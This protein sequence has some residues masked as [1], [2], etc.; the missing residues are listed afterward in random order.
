M[1]RYFI[2]FYMFVFIL[3]TGCIGPVKDVS[4]H[5][6]SMMTIRDSLTTI[7][8]TLFPGDKP[9]KPKKGKH[10]YWYGTNQI[11]IT[12]GDYA[13]RPVDGIYTAF[14][15]S[16]GLV[17]KGNFDKGLKVGIWVRWDL[18]GN[19]IYCIKYRHGIAKDTIRPK[20]TTKPNAEIKDSSVVKPKA[21]E[22]EKPTKKKKHEKEKP[23]T[24]K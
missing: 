4:Y 16:G 21:K 6:S 18:K 24:Q 14:D 8:F 5:P 23:E 11:H 20:V 1:I 7:R 9:V 19:K 12:E 13:G 2:L 17:E 3:M 15:E 10:Y 22:K